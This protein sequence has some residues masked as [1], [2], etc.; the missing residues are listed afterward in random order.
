MIRLSGS[1]KMNHF[2][3]GLA[4]PEYTDCISSV[5]IS[6]PLNSWLVPLSLVKPFL[7]DIFAGTLKTVKKNVIDDWASFTAWQSIVVSDSPLV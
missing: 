4:G 6:V 1:E 2:M 7:A 5:R 3:P